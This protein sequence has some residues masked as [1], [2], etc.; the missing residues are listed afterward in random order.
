MPSIKQGGIKYYFLCLWY[1]SNLDWTQVS[2]AIGEHSNHYNKV[3]NSKFTQNGQNFFKYSIN[4][5]RND[6]YGFKMN[7]SDILFNS[8]SVAVLSVTYPQLTPCAK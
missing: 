7:S 6:L 8:F 1:D 4:T 2:R 3:Q 5:I